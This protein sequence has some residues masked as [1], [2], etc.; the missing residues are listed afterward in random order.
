MSFKSKAMPGILITFEGGEGA[1]KTTL[2][3]KLEQELISRG[4]SV[5]KTRE[6]G[7]SALSEYIRG[8]LLN[9]DFTIAVGNKAELLLFLAARAQHLEEFILPA[10][11]SGKIVLCDRFNDSTIVYQGVARGLGV[12]TVAALCD[13]VCDH[14]RPNLTFLL[15]LNSQAGL[16]RTKKAQKDN[17]KE[18]EVDRIEGEG[19]AFHEKVRQG[20]LSI[21]HQDPERVHVIDASCSI[22]QV[23]QAAL[24]VIQ[25]RLGNYV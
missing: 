5:V 11:K 2:I 18:G 15:D 10:L 16:L 7:G 21:A 19:L 25:E 13:L 20:F 12:S 1:G 22:D 3:Y 17:A 8:W 9:R 6:P 24:N 4:K 23:Y 14:L